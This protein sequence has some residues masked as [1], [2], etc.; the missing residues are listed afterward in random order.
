[1]EGGRKKGKVSSC[2][3]CVC[4]SPVVV[5]PCRLRRNHGRVT[6]SL[7]ISYEL[8]PLALPLSGAS[9]C[10]EP[11]GCPQ[12]CPGGIGKC[13]FHSHSSA[14]LQLFSLILMT[15][16]S[17]S[18]PRSV[19]GVY[20][21]R[22]WRVLATGFDR[23]PQHVSLDPHSVFRGPCFKDLSLFVGELVSFWGATA[24]CLGVFRGSR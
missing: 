9:T 24:V 11:V 18:A 13:K 1:M 20:Q 7:K 19:F 5:F 23:F 12:T 21:K 3:I 16:T 15:R 17:F 10:N 14:F 6:V 22:I 8:I 2:L 4:Y